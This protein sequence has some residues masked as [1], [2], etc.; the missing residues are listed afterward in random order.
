MAVTEQQVLDALRVVRDGARWLVFADGGAR[1]DDLAAALRAAGR[2]VTLVHRGDHFDHSG[3]E[4]TV[5]PAERD[6]Y[7]ALVD[8]VAGGSPVHAIHLTAGE[9]AFVSVALLAAA[10]GRGGGAARLVV[11]TG[12]TAV[13]T[14]SEEIDPPAAAVLGAVAVAEEEHPN[15]TCIAV[16]C[17]ADD[18]DA[19]RL[20]AAE[21][22]SEAKDRGVAVRA[23]RRWVRGWERVEAA[24]E[25]TVEPGSVWLFAGGVDGRS[26]LLAR[27]AAFRGAR[28]VLLDERMS[29]RMAWERVV[30]A[31]EAIRRGR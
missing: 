28:V 12:G 20:V 24:G 2:A 23:R 25:G 15:L 9:D 13:V 19:A 31:R 14:G 30:A 21:A 10:L 3:G 1:A 5:R 18:P 7:A 16:D 26:E 29:D 22:L 11:V 4:A 17:E 27:H 8:A 6:D